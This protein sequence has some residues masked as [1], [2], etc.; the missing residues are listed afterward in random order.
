M[1]FGRH[2][3]T[4]L[5]ARAGGLVTTGTARI[6]SLGLVALGLSGCSVAFPATGVTEQ[7]QAVNRLYDIVLIPVAIIFVLVEGLIIWS[8]VR[9]RR[10]DDTLPTQVHG[11]TKLELTWT[12]LPTLLVLVVF[13]LS[14][15]T[16]GKVDART[17]PPALTV[18]VHAYQWYWE[19]EYPDQGV[20][21]SGLGTEPE[22]VLPTAQTV[23]IRLHSDN[24]I[25]SFYVP[26]FLFKRDVIPGVD[27]E[28]EFKITDP[29]TY[30]GQCAEFCGVG[31]ADMMFN[32]RGVSA[33]EFATWIENQKKAA[34][35]PTASLGADATVLQVSAVNTTSFEQS[36]LDAPAGQPFGIHF[37][38]KEVGTPHDV[39]VK[40]ATGT[41]AFTGDIVTGPAETTYSVPALAVG[42]YTFFCAVH[43]NMH[44]T[45]TVK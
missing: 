31:H 45:L 35:P 17:E 30:R 34:S 29:G 42:N 1:E 25:H 26:L 28:F 22:L 12:I 38:N 6:A 5:A 9:Y 20:K 10:H 24:V 23:R 44:G 7:G 32:V 19:F 4:T 41:V 14:M 15:Q 27:N 33:A 16:L 11:N 21:V 2:L 36:T 40:D 13:V 37:Q 8:V 43:P 3:L 39:A 18:D